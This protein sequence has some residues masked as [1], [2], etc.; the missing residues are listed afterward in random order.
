MREIQ[1]FVFLSTA[2]ALLNDS[3]SS[4]DDDDDATNALVLSF[5]S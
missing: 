4:S 2:S 3:D 5:L 1:D